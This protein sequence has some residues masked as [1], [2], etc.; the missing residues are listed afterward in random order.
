MFLDKSIEDAIS[1]LKR[2]PFITGRSAQK[3]IFYLLKNKH[4]Y[5]VELIRSL[6][7]LL[8]LQ[9]CHLCNMPTADKICNI[10]SSDKRDVHLLMIVEDFADLFAVEQMG[11]Y[12]GR[13]YILNSRLDIKNGIGP[14]DLNI[15]KLLNNIQENNVQE[16]IFGFDQSPEM[17]ATKLFLIEKMKPFNINL[18]S[19]AVGMPFGSELEYADKRTLKHAILNKIEIK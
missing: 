13:Y 16:I 1:T 12:S 9:E 10:C 19:I 8:L 7:R 6:E 5:A 15:E 11:E 4:G 3:I 17:E 18:Y 14:E 2:L